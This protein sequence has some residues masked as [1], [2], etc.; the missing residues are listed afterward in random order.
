MKFPT[1]YVGTYD[2]LPLVSSSVWQ[3]V[4]IGLR[5]TVTLKKRAI[6]LVWLLSSDLYPC[7]SRYPSAGRRHL[8]LSRILCCTL[9]QSFHCSICGSPGNRN[10][11]PLRFLHPLGP[12]IMQSS[13]S[14]SH[15]ISQQSRVGR[16]IQITF[17]LLLTT[18]AC[19][20][21]KSRWGLYHPRNLSCTVSYHLSILQLSV[22]IFQYFF[23]T[24]SSTIANRKGDRVQPWRTPVTTSNHSPL[25]SF[26]FTLLLLSL[27]KFWMMVTIP[28]GIPYC[29]RIADS[30][31]RCICSRR[32]SWSRWN[33]LSLVFAML[34]LFQ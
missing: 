27:Y 34:L 12:H 9:C 29:R 11:R 22:I 14:S 26:I 24:Q 10:P 6:P 30:D 4:A 5:Y 33:L 28:S 21:V 7:S 1:I 17:P 8:M 20:S 13:L 18:F 19:L 3:T 32:L 25:M 15:C 2:V 31:G 16:Y 23:N